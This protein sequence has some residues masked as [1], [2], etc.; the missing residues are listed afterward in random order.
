MYALRSKKQCVTMQSASVKQAFFQLSADAQS[1]DNCPQNTM[2]LATANDLSLRHVLVT[3]GMCWMTVTSS[4]C[5]TL[6]VCFCDM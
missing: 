5:Q 6:A 3:T 4:W 1:A 2:N